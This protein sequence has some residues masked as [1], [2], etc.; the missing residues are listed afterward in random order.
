MDIVLD[1]IV[2]FFVKYQTLLIASTV[3]NTFLYRYIIR[4]LIFLTLCQEGQEKSAGIISRY[5]YFLI[6]GAIGGG[7][8]SLAVL[9]TQFSEM[10]KIQK[11]NTLLDKIKYYLYDFIDIVSLHDFILE[12]WDFKKVYLDSDYEELLKE[13]LKP[14]NL[15]SEEFLSLEVQ[16]TAFNTWTYRKMILK[17]LELFYYMFIR[18]KHVLANVTITSVNTGSNAMPLMESFL[19]LYLKPTLATELYLTVVEDEKAI[20]DN[21]R[22]YADN[23][24][25]GREENDDGKDAFTVILRHLGEEEITMIGVSQ[26]IEDV[27]ANRR[28]LAQATLEVISKRSVYYY[29][30]EIMLLNLLITSIHMTELFELNYLEWKLKILSILNKRI[31]VKKILN[32]INKQIIYI[33]TYDYSNSL[34][35]KIIFRILNLITKLENRLY[36]VQYVNVHE[37]VET[38]GAEIDDNMMYA[39]RVTIMYDANLVYGLY[40]PLSFSY[41]RDIRNKD[42]TIPLSDHEPFKTTKMNKEEY[43]RMGWRAFKKIIHGKDKKDQKKK[44]FAFN[45]DELN[46]D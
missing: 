35:K 21:S 2:S 5:V 12:N 24:K 6:V 10:V 22:T 30:L 43:E 18:T 40:D 36:V 19:Q 37:R 33:N 8:T 45:L 23:S 26:K 15:Y 11:M 44:E 14:L 46:I 39:Y 3:F 29:D 32:Y 4:E 17:Y 28:R 41:I 34:Y 13:F 16:F 20:T 7:K 42:A 1:Q 9:L 38:V 31:K 25:L 27:T